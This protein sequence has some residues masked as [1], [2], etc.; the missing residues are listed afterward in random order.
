MLIGSSNCNWPAS[1]ASFSRS[2]ARPRPQTSS[3]RTAPGTLSS[4]IVMTRRRSGS[5]AAR[6]LPGAA[7]ASSGAS[8][9]QHSEIVAGLEPG[10]GDQR[11]A[12]RLVQRVFE[13]GQPVGRVDVD[14]DQPGLGGS[15]LGHHPFGVVRR[16]DAD[17][18]AGFEAERHQPRGEGIDPLLQLRASSSGFPDGGRSAHRARQSAR[19]PGRNRRRS[20]RR[21]AASRWRRGHSS[22]RSL[23]SVPEF[24]S[25]SAT[26][27]STLKLYRPNPAAAPAA[28]LQQTRPLWLNHLRALRR[29]PAQPIF[30]GRD[31][32]SGTPVPPLKRVNAAKIQCH[33]GNQMVVG[34]VFPSGPS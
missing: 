24:R 34:A 33:Y 18:R 7:A 27:N 17:A 32:P 16:P 15:E 22:A 30:P 6:R 23:R 14:E 12:A 5:C 9:A 19:R 2:A 20:S 10:G 13:L 26:E 28:I 4:P 21:S 25:A 8:V 31:Q 29:C 1:A 3:N 11:G